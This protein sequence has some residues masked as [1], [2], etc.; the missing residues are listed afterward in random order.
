MGKKMGSDGPSLSL[1]TIRMFLPGWHEEMKR[2]GAIGR[3]AEQVVMPGYAFRHR[4]GK[5]SSL[6]EVKTP[7]KVYSRTA[8]IL[9]E[10]DEEAELTE[11]VLK[12]HFA[13]MD[14]LARLI[15]LEDGIEAYVKEY[16]KNPSK[17]DEDEIRE[18]LGLEPASGSA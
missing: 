9:K 1:E 11:L 6:I 3:P 13:T 15:L 10:K 7:G 14:P 17:E 5:F 12:P 4:R 16:K 18:L 2:Q 8:P